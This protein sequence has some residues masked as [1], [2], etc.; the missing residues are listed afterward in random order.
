MERKKKVMSDG[1]VNE[2]AFGRLMGD[3]DGIEAEGM[4]NESD[5]MTGSEPSQIKKMEGVSVEIKP[6]MN[7][8]QTKDAPEVEDEEKEKL[9]YGRLGL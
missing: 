6:M 5:P 3:L 8:E 1:E 7:G 9:K 4:F 2:A